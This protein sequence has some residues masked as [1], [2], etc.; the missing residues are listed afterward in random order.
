MS[1]LEKLENYTNNKT[2]LLSLYDPNKNE[3]IYIKEIF[4]TENNNFILFYNFGT[5]KDNGSY[6]S[7]DC[8][9][10]LEQ[11]L[12]KIDRKGKKITNPITVNHS[13]NEQLKLFLVQD[14]FFL[15]DSKVI[16]RIDKDFKIEKEINNYEICPS[17]GNIDASQKLSNNNIIISMYKFFYILNNNFEIVSKIPKDEK[18]RARDIYELNDGRFFVHGGDEIPNNYEVNGVIF[19]STKLN[20]KFYLINNEGLEKSILNDQ[21]QLRGDGELDVYAENNGKIYYV[22]KFYFECHIID[23]K[24]FQ[25]ETKIK[26][27][28]F[29]GFSFY[30]YDEKLYY[31][32]WKQLTDE[33][34]GLIYFNNKN[35][36]RIVIRD[37]VIIIEET[38]GNG[39][40]SQKEFYFVEL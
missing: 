18:I 16:K 34:P 27:H 37:N 20:D 21:N 2:S 29:G 6:S 1:L 33:L 5:W 17:G 24:N 10:N 23:L 28:C 26:E 7:Y 40:V 15:V 35:I 19:N 12:I 38:I 39:R 36:G 32:T 4:R 22:F 9:E 31:G 30:K 13:N 14:K 8:L 25:L 11:R 3:G